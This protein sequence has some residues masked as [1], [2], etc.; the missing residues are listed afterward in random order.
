[1]THSICFKPKLIKLKAMS[2]T[3]H[4]TVLCMQIH[5]QMMPNDFKFIFDSV[6]FEISV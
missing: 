1:M 5:N 6:F 3:K 2:K 4:N